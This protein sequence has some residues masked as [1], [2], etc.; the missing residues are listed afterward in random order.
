[1][2]RNRARASLSHQVQKNLGDRLRIGESKHAAKESGTIGGGIYSW[3]TYKTYMKHCNYF[4]DYCKV[5][6]GCR[7]LEDCRSH[8]DEWLQSQINRGLSAYTVKLEVSAL[9]KLYN[10]QT[11]DFIATPGR[12]RDKITRSRETVK[13]D[14]N[15]SETKNEALVRFCK[16]TG[17]RRSELR[18]LTGSDLR[19]YGDKFYIS[20]TKG[21][22]GGRERLAPV[23]GDVE[24]VVATMKQAGDGLVFSKVNSNADIHSYRS[25][26][27][28]A[29]YKQHARDISQLRREEIYFCRGDLKG[30]KYDRA[31]MLETSHALGHNRIS[32]IA[33]HYLR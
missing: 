21:V 9:A 18:A 7:T 20:V 6:H 27:A 24:H 1:M 31:A 13:R 30:V 26:Y 10:C 28:V 12:Y 15:F 8:A 25:D 5:T 22:K 17:L 14:K 11:S 3:S 32:V 29:V 4:T 23:V 2:A 33:G 16:S 19:Q